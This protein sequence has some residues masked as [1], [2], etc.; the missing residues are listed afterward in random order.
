MSNEVIQSAAYDNYYN[1]QHV[2]II[3]LQDFIPLFFKLFNGETDLKGKVFHLGIK[4][5]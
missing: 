1:F 4:S 5:L 2:N 3:F